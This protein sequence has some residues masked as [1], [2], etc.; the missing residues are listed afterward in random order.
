MHVSHEFVIFFSVGEYILTKRIGMPVFLSRACE[1]N[2]VA[3][4]DCNFTPTIAKASLLSHKPWPPAFPFGA[5][6]PGNNVNAAPA[7]G[8]ASTFWYC[9]P[10]RKIAGEMFSTSAPPPAA[11]SGEVTTNVFATVV[12]K[13]RVMGLT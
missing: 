1:V 2:S 7:A 5:A 13:R 4:G 12:T 8:V 11:T 9:E 6:V 10:G 3:F